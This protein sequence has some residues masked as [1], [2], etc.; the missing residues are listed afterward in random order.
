MPQTKR[1]AKSVNNTI[2]HRVVQSKFYSSSIN[3][4][5]WWRRSLWQRLV[6]ILMVIVTI[7]VSGSYGIS[8]WYLQRHRHEPLTLGVTF[9]PRYAAFFGLDPKQTMQ[10]I[11]DELGVRRFRLVSYWDDIEKTPG[12]Y[13][14]S[15]L[16]WQFTKAEAA[17]AKVDLAVG[18]RQPRWPECHMP[19]WAAS[20]PESVW[21]PQLRSFM[22][23]VVERYKNSPALISYQ[24]ENE[25]FMT[26][27]GECT[28]F[29][30]N[31]LVTE[32]NLVRR[33]D[34]TKPIVV[35]RS[36]NW[37][38]VPI[39]EPTP[40]IYAVAVYKRVFDYTVMHRYFEYPYP[41]WFYGFLGGLGELIHG[42]PLVIHEL[43]MEPWL[44]NGFAMNDI[45]SIPE[46]NK[47]MNA[48]RLQKRFRYAEDTGLR[49]IDAW[50]VEWWYWRKEKA[51]D[52]SLWNVAKSE[53]TRAN[54]LNTQA[55][56]SEAK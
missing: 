38:G 3:L 54:Q 55:A 17:G 35:T 1:N 53:F 12:T 23:A 49:T 52:P 39:G 44:P 8:Y 20:E 13:D 34:P 10:A 15:Q 6:I 25:F 43:Q 29:D 42:K 33:L 50:G 46:Q 28:N 16:D 37:G 11:I 21:Y 27:F 5:D 36:N 19:T 56:T 7:L 22:T 2:K 41:P 47:S 24:V 4:W 14:F 18:L 51:H 45:A 9:I 40:D 31:R 32:Y 30:R 48:D 26:I